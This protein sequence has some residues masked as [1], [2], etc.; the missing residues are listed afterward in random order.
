MIA[1]D[2]LKGM[3]QT[4]G[5]EPPW[6][7][8]W[9]VGDYVSYGAQR[10]GVFGIGQ[11]ALDAVNMGPTVLGGPTVEQV[12]SGIMD[13]LDKT[14]VSALPANPLYKQAITSRND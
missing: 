9:G 5:D 14:A 2:I 4:G 8:G 11:F 6:K 13:P 1:A 7:K 12:T 10:A 3:L